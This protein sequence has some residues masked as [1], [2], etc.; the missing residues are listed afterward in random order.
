MYRLV[1]HAVPP[2]RVV[3]ELAF[4][5]IR[6]LLTRVVLHHLCHTGYFNASGCRSS[7]YLVGKKGT[8]SVVTSKAR[9]FL[10]RDGGGVPF[11]SSLRSY[12]ARSFDFGAMPQGV[13]HTPFRLSQKCCRI[14]QTTDWSIEQRVSGTTIF[15]VSA[16]VQPHGKVREAWKRVGCLRLCKSKLG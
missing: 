12:W 7:E 11:V 8:P 14:A 9:V 2:P 4:V 15:E 16:C 13:S 6:P 1:L 10:L 3:T 5:A